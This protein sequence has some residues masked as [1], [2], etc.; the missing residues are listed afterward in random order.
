MFRI[1]PAVPVYFAVFEAEDAVF[2]TD[3]D[4]HIVW[5]SQNLVCKSAVYG[6]GGVVVDGGGF[7]D[8]SSHR[9]V[10]VQ[11]DAGDEVFVGEI[12]GAEV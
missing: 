3:L 2:F 10:F 7:V 8:Y 5:A 11:E 4:V 1:E 6:G 9:G 12:G